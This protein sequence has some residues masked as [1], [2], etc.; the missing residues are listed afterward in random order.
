MYLIKRELFNE[1]GDK[2]FSFSLSLSVSPSLS[3]SKE[4]KREGKRERVIK[5]R[6]LLPRILIPILMSREKCFPSVSNLFSLLLL[7]F[8]SSSLPLCSTICLS[9]ERIQPGRKVPQ[10]KRGRRKR[11]RRKREAWNSLPAIINGT[12]YWLTKFSLPSFFS[13]FHLS[14][15]LSF[16]LSFFFSP[17]FWS[18][19]T[20]FYDP[21]G[22]ILYSVL[23]EEKE[24]EEEWSRER[25]EWE[26]EREPLITLVK[27]LSLFEPPTNFSLS[28]FLS[29]FS[30]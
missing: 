26:R 29:F 3:E 6:Y 5:D 25:E 21:W 23:V 24:K 30:S 19:C 15:S 16:P 11:R 7:F 2:R 28:F 13:F 18:I 14:F 4:R 9:V 17:S 27:H 22:T 1:G 12:D 8:L 20:L 10:R